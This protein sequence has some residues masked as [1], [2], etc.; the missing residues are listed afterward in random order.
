MFRRVISVCV[1]AETNDDTWLIE[2]YGMIPNDGQ[3]APPSSKLSLEKID[4]WWHHIFITYFF[5]VGKIELVSKELNH[6]AAILHVYA[7][8]LNFMK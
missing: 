1:P 8:G 7:G 6:L 3:L 4:L 2:I 5:Y